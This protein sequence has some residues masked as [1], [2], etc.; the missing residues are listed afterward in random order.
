MKNNAMA[1]RYQKWQVQFAKSDR[2][3]A[4]IKRN[5]GGLRYEI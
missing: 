3:E 5:I 4:E 2:L 1:Q